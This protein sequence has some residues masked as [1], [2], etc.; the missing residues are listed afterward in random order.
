MDELNPCEVVGGRLSAACLEV[1]SVTT[2]LQDLQEGRR[3]PVRVGAG[4]AAMAAVGFAGLAGPPL[5]EL[6]CARSQGPL[7][8]GLW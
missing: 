1:A 8:T 6:A 2:V 7:N 3:P 5:N 4:A